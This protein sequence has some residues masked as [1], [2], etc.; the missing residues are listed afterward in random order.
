MKLE[1]WNYF[2][3]DGIVHPRMELGRKTDNFTWKGLKKLE[4]RLE[5]FVVGL[6]WR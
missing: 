5:L 2:S 4:G 3:W 1:G 6:D